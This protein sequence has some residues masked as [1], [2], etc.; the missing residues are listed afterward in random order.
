MVPELQLAVESAYQTFANYEI[1]ADID[2][3]A[4][5]GASDEEHARLYRALTTTSLRQ[6]SADTIEAYFEYI[7][8]AHYDG[9][10]NASEVRYFL[11]RA[12]EI[13][14]SGQARST[15]SFIRDHLERILERSSAAWPAAEV[16][17][18][19]QVLKAI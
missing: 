19:N 16:A 14:A 4:A 11:P 18:I 7:T 15:A 13:L 8:A 9:T 6:L 3:A 17:M 2:F 12:L 10:F 1:G 5:V